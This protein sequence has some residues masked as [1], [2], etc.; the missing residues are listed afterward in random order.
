MTHIIYCWKCGTK[1]E[2]SSLGK[3]KCKHCKTL[4]IVGDEKRL[5][6]NRLNYLTRRV[7]NLEQTLR[8]NGIYKD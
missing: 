8:D 2:T 6:S 3:V 7:H 1:I 4:I 5:A